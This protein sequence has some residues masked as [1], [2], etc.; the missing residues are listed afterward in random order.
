M[1]TNEAIHELRRSAGESQQVFSTRLSLSISA[2]QKHETR[3]KPDP[4][5]LLIY[6]REAERVKRDDLADV[7][8]SELI[9]ALA[10]TW[11]QGVFVTADRF[12]TL[13]VTGLVWSLRTRNWL[14]KSWARMVV[15]RMAELMEVFE[16]DEREEFVHLAQER[17]LLKSATKEKKRK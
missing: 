13:A 12:E 6:Q 8:R 3:T 17:G 2:L 4:K 1:T 7:F 16:I 10:L 14:I 11:E 15:R 5:Q 9:K